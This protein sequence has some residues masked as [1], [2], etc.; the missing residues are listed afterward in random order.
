MA[1]LR[2]GLGLDRVAGT[3]AGAC[4]YGITAG[5]LDSPLAARQHPGSGNRGEPPP[6]SAG[7]TQEGAVCGPRA[8]CDQLSRLVDAGRRSAQSG[9]ELEVLC[10]RARVSSSVLRG[11][12]RLGNSPDRA[13]EVD[14]SGCHCSSRRLGHNRGPRSGS[15]IGAPA[16]HC[17][18]LG[19][20]RRPGARVLG[21]GNAITSVTHCGDDS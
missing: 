5:D 9:H 8:D 10:A 15:E 2:C 1:P 21:K 20:G 6:L 13:R 19:Q 16:C 12:D 11:C 7:D 17:P 14:E 18:I 3:P 4:A